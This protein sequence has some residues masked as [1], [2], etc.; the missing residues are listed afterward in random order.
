M[1]STA[2]S[3]PLAFC[4]PHCNQEVI[5]VLEHMCKDSE[6]GVIVKVLHECQVHRGAFLLIIKELNDSRYNTTTLASLMNEVRQFDDRNYRADI[7]KYV[8]EQ[9]EGTPESHAHLL[10]QWLELYQMWSRAMT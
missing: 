3:D 6:L 5:A 7:A 2:V 8:A 1:E 4:R 9:G 10:V